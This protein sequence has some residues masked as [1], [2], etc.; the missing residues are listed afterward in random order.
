MLGGG[1]VG[2]GGIGTTSSDGCD[3]GNG[4]REVVERGTALV[5]GLV[6]G[7]VATAGEVSCDAHC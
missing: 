5:G 4:N 3:A 1:E 7:K 6:P 2:N